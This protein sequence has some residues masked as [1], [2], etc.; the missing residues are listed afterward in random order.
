MPQ[1]LCALELALGAPRHVVL[2]G[3]P[4]SGEF[5]TLAAVLHEG[6]SPWRTILAVTG[7][8]DRQW[9]AARAPWLADMRAIEGRAT[10]YVCEEFTCQAPVHEASGLRT[11]LSR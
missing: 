1:M 7:E 3:E 10:A 4:Q 2:A 6:L 9:L 8:T 5:R 11:L